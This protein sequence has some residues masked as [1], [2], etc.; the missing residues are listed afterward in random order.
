MTIAP[1]HMWLID[2]ETAPHPFAA[3][4]RSICRGFRGD[5]P[6]WMPEHALEAAH[7]SFNS[8]VVVVPGTA[9]R[10]DGLARRIARDPFHLA[11]APNMLVIIADAPPAME[12]AAFFAA[13]LLVNPEGERRSPC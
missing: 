3:S 10:R 1:R 2:T 11:H 8:I 6:T 4:L 5:D 13:N 7:H 12:A 9:A